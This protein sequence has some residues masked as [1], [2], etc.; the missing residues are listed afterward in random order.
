[1]SASLAR[2]VFRPTTL[3]S[4]SSS[5]AAAY[6]P[7]RPRHFYRHA[8]RPAGTHRPSREAN[9]VAHLAVLATLVVSAQYYLSHPD[10]LMFDHPPRSAIGSLPAHHMAQRRQ[11]LSSSSSGPSQSAASPSRSL[12]GRPVASSSGPS[13]SVDPLAA[14]SAPARIQI[15]L[16]PVHPITRNKFRQYADLVA[17]FD[18]VALADVPPDR[19]G[20]RA[21]FSSGGPTTPGYLL[22]DYRTPTAYAPSHPLAFLADLQPHRQVHGIIGV[23]DATEYDR[24]G[25]PALEAALA[26]FEHSLADLPKTFATKVYGFDPSARQLHAAATATERDGLVLVP[27]EGDVAF[28]LK[29]LVADFGAEVLFNFSNMAAQ[30]ESRTSIPTP[31]EQPG[32]AAPF[33]FVPHKPTA[34]ASISTYASTAPKPSSAVPSVKPQQQQQQQPVNLASLGIAPPP[35]SR[36][37][38]GL[39]GGSAAGNQD[40]FLYGQSIQSNMQVHPSVVPSPPPGSVLV[41]PRSRKRVAGREKKLMGDMWLLAGRVH[42]AITSYNEAIALTKGWQDQVWQAS[43]LEGLAVALVVQ[44]TLPKHAVNGRPPPVIPTRADSPAPNAMTDVSLFVSSIPDRLAQAVALYDKMLLPLNRPADAPPPDPDRAHPLLHAEAALRCAYFLLAVYEAHGVMPTALARL[45]A[46]GPSSGPVDDDGDGAD[47]DT[48]ARAAHLGSLAPSNPVARAS[49]AHWA[50]EAYSPHLA[51]LALPVRVRVTSEVA[52]V[53]RRIGYRRKEAFVLRELA[54][55]CAEGVA[56]RRIEVWPVVG[57][58]GSGE[59]SSATTTNVPPEEEGGNRRGGA[60][61]G[62]TAS[63]V[64]TTTATVGNDAI[65]RLS[66]RVCAA[67]GIRVAPPPP[68]PR[69]GKRGKRV[70]MMQGR[71]LELTESGTGAFGW[72]GLQVGVLKDAIAIAETLPDHQAAIRFTVTALRTLS[73]TMPP[74]EQYEL[75]QSIPRI[76]GAATRRGVP[77]ELE[78]WGPTQLVMS[79]EVARLA[80][81]RAAVEH[82]LQH[83]SAESTQVEEAG[84]RNPFIWDP[85]KG[86]RKSTKLKPTLVEHELTEVLVTLQNPYLFDLEIQS[87]ELSTSGVPFAADSISTVVPPGSFH[88]VRLTG[89]PRGPGAL[90]VRGCHIRLAGCPTREFVLPVWDADEETR[91]R[92]AELVDTSKDRVKRSGLAATAAAIPSP[93]PPSS[94]DDDDESTTTNA[95]FLECVVVPEQPLL[96]MRS[97]SL[98]HGALMLYDGE[99]STIRI[100]LENTSAVPI[101]FVKLSFTDSLA[102]SIE[103]YLADHDVPAVEAF[104]LASEVQHRPVFTWDGAA[105]NTTTSIL[106]GAAHVLEVKCLGKIG[107]GSGTIQ[108]D[109]GHLDRDVVRSTKT[110]H[111]RQ[112]FCDVLITVHR[113]VVATAL[114]V[115]PL[116]AVPESV[117]HRATAAHDR[118]ASV[119]DLGRRDAALDRRLEASLRDVDDGRHCLVAVDVMNVYGKPFEVTLE[120][121]EEHNDFYQVRQRIEPGATLRML[122][123]LDRLSLTH[124]ELDRPIPVLSERQFIVAKVKRSREEERAEREMFW[125]RQELFS[126]VDLRWNEVGSLRTGSI[127]LRHLALDA[128]HLANVRLDDVAVDLFLAENPAATPASFELRGRGHRLVYDARPDEFI[129]VCARV[130]NDS[131]SRQTF[132]LRLDL[133][134]HHGGG[135]GDGRSSREAVAHLARYVIVEGVSPVDLAPLAPGQ[136]ADARVSVCLLARGRYEFGCVVEQV[137]VAAADDDDDDGKDKDGKQEE[138]RRRRPTRRWQAGERI[139]IHV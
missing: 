73:D 75:G 16:V 108:I 3:A 103:A 111:T 70:S 79:L 10:A 113:A 27:G 116:R 11:T 125:Y 124:E 134:A 78:Y 59:R 63:V 64:R 6:H 2:T 122:V 109:Y 118:S 7:S 48:A 102:Q 8:G 133:D 95:K 34:R 90:V 97:T 44:A 35:Q 76:F 112:L 139:V 96:W 131:R 88:T 1:M 123:R 49:I 36:T 66:E 15:L 41:D 25:R 14:F 53:F 132:R 129:D 81:N 106:P 87:I 117:V 137:D 130:T 107:C 105:S 26:S 94:T 74:V 77:F 71:A 19:R 84:P 93:P 31:Q 37:A 65:V 82:P 67:F 114:D 119:V 92:K 46:G 43:A 100:A 32:P 121:K 85:R 23:L 12:R 50:S 5:G 99:I 136:T 72:P 39:W 135:G 22:F 21:T 80:P 38:Q 128:R 98:T 18:R 47:T 55:L 17:T 45:V 42:E 9:L 127:S 69:T 4:T 104:E 30:L 57:G 68:P 91:R 83:A 13:L 61:G 101:D 138:R 86:S 62:R 33:S 54:A 51:R 28:F 89:T 52:S 126:R 56:G 60:G 58:G 120:R 110:F 115:S 40:G 29:T 24:D 20:D